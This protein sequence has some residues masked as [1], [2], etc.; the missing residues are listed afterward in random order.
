MGHRKGQDDGM[1]ARRL[2]A[3]GLV[4]LVTTVAAGC[5]TKDESQQNPCPELSVRSGTALPKVGLTAKE[6]KVQTKC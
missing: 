2:V 1:R 6:L 4:A 3:V 5:S